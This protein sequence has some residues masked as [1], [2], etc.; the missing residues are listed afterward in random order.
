MVFAVRRLCLALALLSLGVACRNASEPTGKDWDAYPWD[1]VRFE[2][3]EPRFSAFLAKAEPAV[4]M[5]GYLSAVLIASNDHDTASSTYFGPCSFGLRLY[6]SPQFFGDPVWDNRVDGCEVPLFFI[7]LAPGETKS[8]TLWAALNPT[9][10]ADS[11]P[12]GEYH[13][14]VTWRRAPGARMQLIPSGRVRIGR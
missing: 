11:L 10:L 13:V 12:A 9:V 8:R 2:G 4:Y 5:P 6:I 14:A 1:N 3:P 7:S